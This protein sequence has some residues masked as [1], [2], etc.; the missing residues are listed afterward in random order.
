MARPIQ[1][2]PVLKGEDAKR[3]KQDMLDMVKSLTKALSPE[4][5]KAMDQ[6]RRKIKENHD[7]IAS[8]AHGSCL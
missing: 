1:D 3:F 4:E 2:T 8:I 5:K 7:L 6:E